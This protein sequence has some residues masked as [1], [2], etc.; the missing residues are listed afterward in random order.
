[1]KDRSLLHN[2]LLAQE[3]MKGYN[4]ATLSPRCI[5]KV[6]LKKAY[7][8]ISWKFLL[9]LLQ[10]LCF[11]QPFIRWVEACVC[12]AKYSL[13]LN[14]DSVGFIHGRKGLRQGDP[15]SPLLFVLIMDY[16]TRLLDLSAQS[17]AFHFHPGCK[18]E[19]ILSLCFADDL[20]I[21]S[22][23]TE[24]AVHCLLT[25]FQEFST[26]TGLA[27]NGSKSNIYFGGFQCLYSRG[28]WL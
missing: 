19:R 6:D 28:C 12:S 10:A 13:V 21:F 11:P 14:G 16:F 9:Q 8:S 15:L 3:L 22:K 2:V 18:K 1:M 4:R 24:P 5:M 17:P 20:L 23:G 26:L 27:A 7:D 25:A